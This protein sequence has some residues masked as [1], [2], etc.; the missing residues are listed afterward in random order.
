MEQQLTSQD[1]TS[2][3]INRP[4]KKTIATVMLLVF[5][6]CNVLFM[7]RILGVYLNLI[8]IRGEKWENAF[9][10]MEFFALVW[11]L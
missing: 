1:T 9:T 6:K 3:S 11:Y 8:K 10:E 5:H 2:S 4:S 7:I